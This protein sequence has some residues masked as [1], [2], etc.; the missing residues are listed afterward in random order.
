MKKLVIGILISAGFIYLSLR[1][2]EIEEAWSSLKGVRY[3]FL[4]PAALIFCLVQVFRSIRWGVLLSPIEEIDQKT[5]FPI[6][7]IGYMA[8]IVAP[9]RM[10]EIVRPYLVNIKRSVPMGSGIATVF[11][12]RVIDILMLLAFLF[13]V[14]LQIPLPY[15]LVRGGNVLLAIIL[16]ALTLIVILII[17]PEVVAKILFLLTSRLP[18]RISARIERF[19]LNLINGFMVISDMKKLF[20]VFSLSFMIWIFSALAVYMLFSFYNLHLGI[21]EAFTVMVITT[22]GIGIPSAPG[23]LGNFQFACIVALSLWGVSKT[24]ALTFAMIYY[25]LGIGIIIFLSLIFL[26]F[27]DVPMKQMVSSKYFKKN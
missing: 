5:L 11:I 18:Q 20:Q 12:E 9:A 3:G 8:I 13:L 14:L 4:F 6:T 24:D 1:G 25:F 22:L 23:F 19:I 26:P 17:R 10:G 2:V 27:I 7:C 15:W 21:T 16:S